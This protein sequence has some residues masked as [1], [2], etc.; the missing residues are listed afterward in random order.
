MKKNTRLVL[1]LTVALSLLCGCASSN[2]SPRRPDGRRLTDD[3]LRGRSDAVKG[4]Y[5][6]LQDQQRTKA[7][8]ESYRL[9]E[10]TIPEHSEDGVLVRPTKRVLRIQE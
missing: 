10:L 6:N 2:P 9:Y 3:Y 7:A 1:T 5:W 8:S 4:T